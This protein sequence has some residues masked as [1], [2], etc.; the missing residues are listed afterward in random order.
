MQALEEK[1][2]LEKQMQSGELSSTGQ[3]RAS[4]LL[5]LLQEYGSLPLSSVK[6]I[7]WRLRRLER[8]GLFQY[9]ISPIVA[10]M[11]QRKLVVVQG[12]IWLLQIF[13]TYLI[14]ALYR[15]RRDYRDA[16]MNGEQGKFFPPFVL[17]TDEAHN[18]APKATDSPTKS[19]LKEIAQEGRKYGVFLI[20][21]TQRPGLLDE[22]ITAQL[23][24]KFIF[25]TVRGTDIA[26]LREETDLTPE[27]GKRLP[28][29]SSG[30]TFVSFSDLWP[31]A[32]CADSCCLY[33]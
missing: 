20:L 22:T 7:D 15:W 30:D 9:D 16:K 13:A 26:L 8:A 32:L 17:V 28:Y 23:N 18:F 4:D 6:G 12:S 24:T 31:D 19:V 2:D 27:E 11:E 33:V 21:A 14:G 5:K 3:A 1:R 29:L 25:R 10:N